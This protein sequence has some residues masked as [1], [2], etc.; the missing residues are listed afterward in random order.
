MMSIQVFLANGFSFW[1]TAV[2]GCYHPEYWQELDD[3]A[4]LSGDSRL[5]TVIL[6]DLL[7]MREIT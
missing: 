1:L 7:V 6:V 5:L 3:V 2:Y 4:G